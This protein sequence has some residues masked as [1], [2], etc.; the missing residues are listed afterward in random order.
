MSEQK[1]TEKIEDVQKNVNKLAYPAII[2]D[3]EFRIIF[4]NDFCNNRLIPLRMGSTIKIHLST[5]E[6]RRLSQMLPGE[7]ISISLDLNTLCC[8]Y[9]YRF[10]NCYIIGLKTLSSMLQNRIG[11]LMKINTELTSALLCQINTIAWE[12]DGTGITDL[13]KKKSN[14][15]IRTQQHIGEF[16][17]IVNGVKNTKTQTF[18]IDSILNALMNSL[19]DTLRPLGLQ[20]NYKN[21]REAIEPRYAC[22]CEPDFN[23][24]ICLSLYNCI[25]LSQNGKVQISSKVICNELYISFMTDSVLPEEKA[26]HIC[27]CE[28]EAESFQPPDGWIYFELLLIKILC[29][30]YMWNFKISA[31]GSNYS[32]IQLTL[33]FPL[34]KGTNPDLNV[35]SNEAVENQIK[36]QIALE[37][38][39]ILDRD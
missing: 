21:G 19:S 37:L 39:N 7:I 20:I 30:F 35:K 29:E 31:P 25:I 27:E 8:A 16:L 23:T 18:M 26:K 22:I 10:I 3:N 32:K 38:S 15:I 12:S 9:V 24:I 34:I 33:S 13:I 11:D 17:R 2:L 36:D 1:T 14:R 4:K 6:F 28:L 5:A